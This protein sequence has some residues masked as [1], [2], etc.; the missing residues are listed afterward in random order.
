[1]TTGTQPTL[2]E[3]LRQLLSLIEG[4]STWDP[5]CCRDKFGKPVPADDPQ[6]ATFTLMAALRKVQ[7]AGDELWLAL[8]EAA[9]RLDFGGKSLEQINTEAGHA[10]VVDIITEALDT[11]EEGE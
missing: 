9:E 1:L 8:S 10:A 11:A 7:P 4:E 2:A 6:A 5:K 3:L